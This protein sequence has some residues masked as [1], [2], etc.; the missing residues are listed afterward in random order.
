MMS[1][2]TCLTN[3]GRIFTSEAEHH[4]SKRISGN[5]LRTDTTRLS[6]SKWCHV[7]TFC[8][9]KHLY[10]HIDDAKKERTSVKQCRGCHR[11]NSSNTS[12]SVSNKQAEE[13]VT[14]FLAKHVPK[15]YAPLGIISN[16]SDSERE[17]QR[18]GT[19]GVNQSRE[20]MERPNTKYCYRHRPD[21]RCR[22]QAD[23]PSME[24]LQAV[25][26]PI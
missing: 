10:F 1:T 17:T 23:E 7:M 6:T 9:N 22:R 26:F 16:N 18:N 8:L 11:C 19:S 13:A 12:I 3:E 20:Q 14:P 21:L 4:R 15:Q 5:E 25:S 2:K 24:Q